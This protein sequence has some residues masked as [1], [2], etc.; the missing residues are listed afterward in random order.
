MG[1][2]TWCKEDWEG[3]VG[4]HSVYRGKRLCLMGCPLGGV[5]QTPKGHSEYW[6][7]KNWLKV[8]LQIWPL[9]GW[10]IWECEEVET[11][12]LAQERL[13]N[14][15]GVVGSEPGEQIQPAR[16]DVSECL[17]SLPEDVLVGCQS[18]WMAAVAVSRWE[19]TGWPGI[20]WRVSHILPSW[21]GST[22]YFT[23][24]KLEL[25]KVL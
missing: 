24:E 13:I 8:Y 20:L 14:R 16:A 23:G 15:G 1:L 9:W 4:V 10:T 12:Y 3:C 18:A 21:L 11:C 2:G 19:L 25:W 5:P 6:L 22:Y 17:W 7:S